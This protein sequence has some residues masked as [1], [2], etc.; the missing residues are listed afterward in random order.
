MNKTFIWGLCGVLLIS[1]GSVLETNR[2]GDICTNLGGFLIIMWL[3]LFL[4]DHIRNRNEE[5]KK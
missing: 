1:L 5:N 3:I 4:I 2:F